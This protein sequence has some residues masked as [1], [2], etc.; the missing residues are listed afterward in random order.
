MKKILI[1]FL[2]L[3]MASIVN[4][5]LVFG[6]FVDNGDG[7]GS[8]GVVL[9]AAD[10]LFGIDVSINVLYGTCAIGSA[11]STAD[12]LF[13]G[14]NPGGNQVK[15]AELP[16]GTNQSRRYSGLDFPGVSWITGP[17]TVI[18]N[19]PITCSVPFG[20]ELY[21]YYPGTPIIP[22]GGSQTYLPT[23]R[24]DFFPEPMTMT[25]LGLGGLV[26]VRRRR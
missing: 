22:E 1:L 24:L 26:M 21:N 9:D 10:Q 20:V 12:F 19:I 14:V 8:F 23:G 3:G 16:G 4:A 25:L 2:V 11:T 17:G 5:A 7:T 18:M 15:I 6:D 13:G